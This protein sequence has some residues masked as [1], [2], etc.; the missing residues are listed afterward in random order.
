LEGDENATAELMKFPGLY[1]VLQKAEEKYK[2]GE[3]A[4]WEDVN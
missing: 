2:K 1:E 4:R 3:F